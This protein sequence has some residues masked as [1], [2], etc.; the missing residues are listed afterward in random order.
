MCPDPREKIGLELEADRQLVG[1]RLVGPALQCVDLVADPQQVLDV[2]PDLVRDH[3]GLGEIA[4]G[5][6]FLLSAPERSPGRGRLSDRP[7]SKTGRQPNSPARRRTGLHRGTAR[8]LAWRISCSYS[9][10]ISSQTSSVSARTTRTN[11]FRS[12]SAA[13]PGTGAPPGCGA[14]C[15]LFWIRLTTCRGSA[16][17]ERGDEHDDQRAYAAADGDAG[18]NP[19]PVLDIV[20]STTFLPT[21]GISLE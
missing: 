12:S 11:S 5:F 14:A 16:P 3:V 19:S 1:P 17:R 7:D 6:E 10:K 2:M 9:G 8:E 18:G 13:S 21:H 4:R 15:W 20:A